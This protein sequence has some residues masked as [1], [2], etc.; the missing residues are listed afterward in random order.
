[1]AVDRLLDGLSVDIEQL[2]LQFDRFFNG[3]AAIP[4]EDLR[5]RVAVALRDLRNVSLKSSADRFRLSSLE[6]RFNSFNEL[7]NR[8]LREREEGAVGRPAALLAE[9]RREF[10]AAAGIVLDPGLEPDAVS[11]LHA[12]LFHNQRGGSDLE[13]F[14][15]YLAKQL[16]LVREKTGATSVQFRVALEDGKLKLKAKP[17]GGSRGTS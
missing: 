13:T 4:P 16:D 15:G 7:F 9:S 17:V 8:R 1:M 10:D 2:K 6:A 14:R 5:Q 11:A 12:G 3:A